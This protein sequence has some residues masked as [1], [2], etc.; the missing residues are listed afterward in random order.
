MR[1]FPLKEKELRK[2]N[3]ESKTKI[4]YRSISLRGK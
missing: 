4:L 3:T 1:L 2:N